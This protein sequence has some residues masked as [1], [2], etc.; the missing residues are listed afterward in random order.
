M[1]DAIQLRYS[2]I[3]YI[4]TYAREAYDSGVSLCR[5]MYYDYP[6]LEEAYKYDGQYMFGD[7][8]L[9]A[10]IAVSD[11]G[12]GNVDKTV[13]L[14]EGKWYEAATGTLLNGGGEVTRPF[15][16]GQ[17][18]YYYKEGAIIPLNPKISHLKERPE[19]LILQ[20]VP[21][22]AGEFSYYE[23]ENDTDNYLTDKCTFTKINQSTLDKT[24][25]YTVSPRTGS[26]DGMPS[27]RS[28]KFELLAKGKPTSVTVNNASYDLGAPGT[29]GT[30]SY[31]AE[32]AIV[33]IMIPSQSC[34]AALTVKVINE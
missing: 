10:P 7:E 30:Y 17:I 23:D 3:P 29:V 19:M 15:T 6:E 28:Y 32:K 18:P 4:Y 9:A 1:R 26:F 13:W 16:Q 8:I 24:S 25:T 31:D 33:S 27:K 2:L 11:N 34:D 12:T 5:P 22:A 21:G 14:P 20:F